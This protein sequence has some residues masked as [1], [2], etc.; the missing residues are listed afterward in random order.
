MG[1]REVRRMAGL[2]DSGSAPNDPIVA[3]LAR[4]PVSVSEKLTLRSLA[5]VLTE[6]AVGAAI[7]A[8]ED[9]GAAIVSERDITR[10]LADGADPDTIWSADVMSVTLVDADADDSILEVAF[11]MLDRDIRH[12]VVRDGDQILGVVSA[13]EVFRV[14]A[15]D[16]LDARR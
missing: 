7:V 1:E 8:L 13:R 3:L 14:L 12:V 16:V 2:R 10:A 6:A 11:L 4:G 15:V 9:G 5:A